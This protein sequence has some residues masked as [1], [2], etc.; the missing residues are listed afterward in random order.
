MS[1][2]RIII[3]NGIDF[4]E[5]AQ[6]TAQRKGYKSCKDYIVHLVEMDTNNTN[7]SLQS[8][9]TKGQLNNLYASVQSLTNNPQLKHLNSPYI[10]ADIQRMEAILCQMIQ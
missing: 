2:G 5:K 6:K 10:N 3:E 7:L 8:D 1:N 4:K 9:H